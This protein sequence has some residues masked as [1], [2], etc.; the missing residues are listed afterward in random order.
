MEMTKQV[1][2]LEQEREKE[3]GRCVITFTMAIAICCSV[4]KPKKT[5]K[6]KAVGDLFSKHIQDLI[7][8]F[9]STI[10]NRLDKTSN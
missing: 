5:K 4:A 2:K 7:K 3:T 10:K 8:S 9:L 6:T 1:I